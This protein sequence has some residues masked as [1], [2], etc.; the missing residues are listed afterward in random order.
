MTKP[1]GAADEDFHIAVMRARSRGLSKGEIEAA[2]R[3]AMIEAGIARRRGRPKGS[4]RHGG[5]TKHLL[6]MVDLI[7]DEECATVAQ[8]ASYCA[9]WLT[10]ASHLCP[11]AAEMINIYSGGDA[12]LRNQQDTNQYNSDILREI[13]AINFE[14]H[15]KRLITSFCDAVDG[16]I[17]KDGDCA[18]LATDIK[19]AL[20]KEGLRHGRPMVAAM[21]AILRSRKLI[22]HIAGV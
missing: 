14:S 5:D 2:F 15:K 20:T 1:T 10:P 7:I 9:A 16:L 22:D 12:V 13:A 11:L 17:K 4:T 8:A 21:I 6:E 19:E 18:W 3:R